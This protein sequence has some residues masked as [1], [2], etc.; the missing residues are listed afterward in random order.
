MDR[1]CINPRSVRG[2]GC[3]FDTKTDLKANTIIMPSRL[4][5]LL[6]SAD[7]GI[8]LGLTRGQESTRAQQLPNT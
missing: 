4:V 3:V 6:R 8:K 1:D 2:D 7:Q 5:V